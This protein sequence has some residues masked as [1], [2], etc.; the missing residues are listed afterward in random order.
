MSEHNV[1]NLADFDMLVS[2]L[3]EEF[4]N[5]GSKASVITYE[6]VTKKRTSKQNNSIQKY[7]RIMAEKLNAAGLDMRKVLK[8][9]YE[10]PWTTNSFREQMF[11]RISLV[12]FDKTSSQLE[13][14]EPSEVHKVLDKNLAEKFNVSN[15]FPS[16]R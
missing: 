13:T 16:L 6:P 9:E 11:N 5:N 15:D 4:I 10:I 3:R 2:C 7:C 8:P 1:N 12:M 14:T